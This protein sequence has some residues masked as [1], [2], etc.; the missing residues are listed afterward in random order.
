M[1]RTCEH[2]VRSSTSTLPVVGA[3]MLLLIVDRET[4]TVTFLF[5]FQIATLGNGKYNR[6]HQATQF[7]LPHSKVGI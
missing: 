1:H 2:R 7:F 3:A 4:V 6:Y 5:K